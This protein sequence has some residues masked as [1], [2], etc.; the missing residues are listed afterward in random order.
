MIQKSHVQHPQ[1]SNDQKA[2]IDDPQFLESQHDEIRCI[3]TP[4][5]QQCSHAIQN[6]H[7]GLF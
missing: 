1:K 2:N 7:Q 6:E 3:N 5:E 4:R